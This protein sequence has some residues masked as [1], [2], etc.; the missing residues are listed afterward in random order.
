MAPN[1]GILR[2]ESFKARTPAG[3]N[4]LW[5][6]LKSSPRT[7]MEFLLWARLRGREEPPK[8]S[9]I[10]LVLETRDIGREDGADVF[11]VAPS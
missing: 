10:L 7:D 6:P 1:L 9:S 3:K 2:G 8:M 4:L 5:W 11:R